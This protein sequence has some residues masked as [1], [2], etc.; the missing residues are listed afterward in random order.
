MEER[1]TIRG[2]PALPV[3]ASPSALA[4]TL[5][6]LRQTPPSR[7]EQKFPLFVAGYEL[8]EE[9]GQGGMGI[10]YKARQI[11]LD[12]VVALKMLRTRSANRDD[13]LRFRTEAEAVARLIHPNIVQIY[14]IGEHQGQPY[15]SLEY[16]A[17][18]SLDQHLEGKP[19]AAT[20]AAQLVRRLA[21][22]IQHAH[23]RGVLHRDLKPANVLL[24]PVSQGWVP[25]SGES[26]SGLEGGKS[27]SL[28][29]GLRLPYEPKVTDFGLA[30]KLDAI[31]GNTL[32]GEIVGTPSYMAPEQAE[33]KVSI[34][35]ACDIWALG[36][37]LYECLTG[38]AP[39]MGNSVLETLDQVRRHEPAPPRS[40]CPGIPRDLE[41]VCLKCLD[42]NPARRYASAQALAEDLGR[43]LEGEPILARP[44]GPVE[45]LLKWTRRRPTAGLLVLV[46][47]LLIAV[48]LTAVPLHIYWL[49]QRVAE[50]QQQMKQAYEQTRR[51]EY[52]EKLARGREALA[53][54][55][56]RDTEQAMG[57]FATVQQSIDEE[58]AS[59]DGE[60]KRLRDQASQE[61]M[62]ALEQ[63]E[64]L[65][66]AGP[67]RAQAREFLRL[68]D[69]AFFELH[70]DL[71][72][73]SDTAHP[74]A[75]LEACQKAL[76]LFPSLECLTSKEQTRLR[77][78]RCEVLL[79]LAEATARVRPDRT[80]LCDALCLLEEAVRENGPQHGGHLRRARYLE[81]LGERASAERERQQA[82]NTPARS[83]LDWFVRG[84]ESWLAGNFRAAVEDL[85][86]ALSRDP[87]LYWGRL[88][89]AVAL[90]RLSRFTEA[91]AELGLC[92]RS[93]P[94]LAWPYL[95]RAMLLLQTKQYQAA[96][97][98]L[99]VVEQLELD[100]G[101]RYVL[102]NA[103]GLLALAQKDYPRAMREFQH[104]IFLRPRHHAA[105]VNLAEAH[106][107]SQDPEQALAILDHV[108]QREPCRPELFRT[109]CSM[110]L[111]MGEIS[112]ALRDLECAMQLCGQGTLSSRQ[113]AADLR[114]RARMLYLLG[115]HAEALPFCEEALACKGNDPAGLR[116]HAELLLELGRPR[117]AWKAFD[118]YLKV[119]K[120]DV[121]VYR[122]RARARAAVGDLAGVVED[123]TLA[124]GLSGEP[125][126]YLARGWARLV[127]GTPGE[128]RR[129]FETVLRE[130]PGHAEALI[131]RGAARA[132][133][134]EW[135][136]A[137]ADL[138]AGLARRPRSARVLYNAAR[139][140]ARAAGKLPGQSREL[141]GRSLAV[142]RQAIQAV[143]EADRQRFIR[144][145]IRRDEAFRVLSARG[146]LDRLEKE[147][148]ERETPPAR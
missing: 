10:V 58:E 28:R 91:K 64:K 77:Q 78:V 103:R 84:Q 66:S 127:Q 76:E 145:Q 83:A 38:R 19:L 71:R 102:R 89:R 95:Q 90:Q 104:A 139:G 132:D 128:A 100:P 72:G 23:E 88:L 61:R 133:L 142:L 81:L 110:L 92:I 111:E 29:T 129:D 56:L 69:R 16:V 116:L 18:G 54:G 43:F 131:G 20:T 109:R 67:A 39:F 32:A 97:Q 73:V 113:R 9:I 8:L 55:K 126:L 60:L 30:K 101:A 62:R 13:L 63:L 80:G 34:D 21:M 134:G 68:R 17:G 148:S 37:V 98:E 114:E 96:S 86:Q 46:S 33:G 57:L 24:A 117:E 49:R 75:A 112:E 87:D 31:S 52:E 79:L 137:V 99:Q 136:A 12:R 25:D 106:W 105:Y 6:D 121:E 119:G 26:A 107:Q 3:R 40:L 70:Q 7:T 94:E 115:R 120:P 2:N 85:E 130:I 35:H 11:Q 125:S 59:R 27:T 144:E 47:L 147:S 15:F 48:V 42:K 108:L 36:A 51:T 138:E 4:T 45:R 82:R 1:A 93:R 50:I 123:Y 122:R 22:A 5:R 41:I 74:Q 135:R 65:L 146:S 124:L 14:E 44:V 141:Q 118:R 140:L 53:R 143:P